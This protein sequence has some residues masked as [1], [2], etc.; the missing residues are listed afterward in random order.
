MNET[1]DW[2][3]VQNVEVNNLYLIRYYLDYEINENDDICMCGTH[4]RDEK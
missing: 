4:G 1:T 3:K 2:I